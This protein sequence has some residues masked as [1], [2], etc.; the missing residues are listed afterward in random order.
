MAGGAAAA[1][2]AAAAQRLLQ[3]EEEEMTTYGP[4]DLDDWEFKIVRANR[5]VFGNP[6]TLSRVLAEEARAGWTMV[7]KFD[8]SRIRF[9]RRRR[10]RLDDAKLPHGVDPY[11][12]HHGLPPAAFGVLLVVRILGLVCGVMALIYLLVNGL[13]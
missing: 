10:A 6:G 7:E 1:A 8:N 9:K 11:L 3:L 2:A 12:V 4:D 13:L 5:A